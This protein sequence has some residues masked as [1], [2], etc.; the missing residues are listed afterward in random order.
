MSDNQ[1]WTHGIYGVKVTICPGAAFSY[2]GNSCT[3]VSSFSEVSIAILKWHNIIGKA[4][5]GKL[6]IP[7][8]ICHSTIGTLYDRDAF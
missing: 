1:V 6:T 7:H 8:Y 5:L 4:L 3:E 2:I